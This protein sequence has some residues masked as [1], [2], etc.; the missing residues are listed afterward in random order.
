M[1]NTVAAAKFN[2]LTQKQIRL[3]SAEFFSSKASELLELIYSMLNEWAGIS[4]AE[5]QDLYSGEIT[6]PCLSRLC[7]IS[8]FREILCEL[9]VS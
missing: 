7:K 1:E 8:R 2:D 5:S 9:D 3:Q 6:R 4:P